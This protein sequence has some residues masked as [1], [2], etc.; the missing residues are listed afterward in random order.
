MKIALLALLISM[1]MSPALF[2]DPAVT[3]SQPLTGKYLHV[4]G[5]MAVGLFAAG[6]VDM[7]VDPA[8]LAR[9]PW[10]LPAAGIAGA[11]VAGIGKEVLDATG[12]GDPNL[13]DIFITSAGGLAAALAVGYAQALS[14]PTRNGQLNSGAY[15][16]SA[17]LLAAA[18]VVNGFLVEIR[19][20]AARRA[21]P[22][23]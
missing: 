5:G 17:A 9:S 3:L 15:I 18:P 7:T 23:P 21:R 20:Y 22:S 16:F 12:F 11:V 1:A 19:R 2:A 8:V 6:V 14:E 13:S 4:L 10:L